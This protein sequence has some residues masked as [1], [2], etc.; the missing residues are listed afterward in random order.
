MPIDLIDDFDNEYTFLDNDGPIF[1]FKTDL[2]APRGRVIA[3][4]MR[5]PD[6]DE[7][8]GDH[9][10]GEGEPDRASAWSAISSS[11]PI[12]RTPTRR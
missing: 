7:L 5:K 12:S 2:E 6:R 4:D 10:A 8:E 1:Y 9:P 11:P 3:I